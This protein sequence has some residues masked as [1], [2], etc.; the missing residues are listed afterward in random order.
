[1]LDVER[2]EHRLV[3]GLVLGDRRGMRDLRSS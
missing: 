3:L 1:V 2:D